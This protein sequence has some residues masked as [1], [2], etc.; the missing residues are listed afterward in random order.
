MEFRHC[1][2]ASQSRTLLWVELFEQRCGTQGNG[3]LEEGDWDYAVEL[4]QCRVL[5]EALDFAQSSGF[6]ISV[7]S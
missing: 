3:A 2:E 1:N 7:T 5:M 6:Q 4:D